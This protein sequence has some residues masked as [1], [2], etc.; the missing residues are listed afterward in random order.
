MKAT[1][2]KLTLAVLI[3]LTVLLI[4]IPVYAAPIG[5]L[6]EDDLVAQWKF[7][8]T[9]GST[10]YDSLG[11]YNGKANGTTI[12]PGVEGKARRFNGTS[13]TITFTNTVIPTGNKTIKFSI[14]RSTIPQSFEW[15]FTTG[16]NQIAGEANCTAYIRPISDANAG[17]LSI[18]I[19]GGDIE[20]TVLG[21][22]TTNICDNQWHNVVVVFDNDSRR[23]IVYIDDFNI[24]VVTK[25]YKTGNSDN[26][27]YTRN[28]KMGAYYNKTT[29]GDS[30]YYAGDLDE[31]EI[32]NKCYLPAPQNLT[33][34]AG[35]TKV[36][37]NWKAVEGAS[38]YKIKYGTQP[39]GPYDKEQTVTDT[40]YGTV[41]E[42]KNGTTYYFVVTAVN[43]DGESQPSKEVSATPK[44]EEQ[45]SSGKI[46]LKTDDGLIYSGDLVEQTS[47]LFKLKNVYLY[48]G[49]PSFSSSNQP[50]YNWEISF[51]KNKVI[52]FY[53]GE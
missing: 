51:F 13:D 36:A 11:N 41:D 8:E 20:S 16:I 31:F 12:I 39:G 6:T 17:A 2:R 3:V 43:T 1:Y 48:N 42:L 47:E 40:V 25:D 29:G 50:T 32:Y 35:N 24:P 18:A 9:S 5:N 27:A 45:P 19:S 23:A 26:T 37:L 7:D 33:A 15:V 53:F 38:G 22:N 21:V 44:A 4:S 49:I 28:L 30:S 46:M 34:E 10:V 52:W 14:R